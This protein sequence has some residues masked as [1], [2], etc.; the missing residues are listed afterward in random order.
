MAATIYLVHGG[1]GVI[2]LKSY[3]AAHVND[4]SRS[5]GIYFISQYFKILKK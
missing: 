3:I 2:L 4:G 1:V 5:F